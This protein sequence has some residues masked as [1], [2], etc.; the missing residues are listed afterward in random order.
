MRVRWRIFGFMFAFAFLAYLQRQASTIAAE[1]M[2]PELG[3]SQLQFGFLFWAFMLGYTLLQLASGVYGQRWGPRWMFFGASIVAAL[4]VL[5]TPLA[6]FVAAGTVLFGVLLVAQLVLGIAQAPVFP[7]ASGIFEAWFPKQ[8]WALVQ[9][10]ESVGQNLGAALAP[11]MIATI[12]HSFGWRPAVAAVALVAIPFIALW[13]WYGRDTPAEHPRVSQI[14]LAELGDD[15]TAADRSIDW[16]RLRRLLANRDVLTI[17]ASY[18]I[19]NYV[20]YL[21]SVWSFLYLVQERHFTVLEGGWLAAGPPLAAAL[22]AGAGGKIAET[23][24]ARYGSRWGFRLVP[25][26]ALPVSGI[27]L[28]AAVTVQNGYWAAAAMSA[29]FG[30]IELVEGPAWAAVMNVARDDTMA[31]TGI[32]N[33]GGCIGGLVGVPIVAYLSGER[34]WTAAIVIGAVAALV[35]GLAWLAADPSRRFDAAPDAA[36]AAAASQGV[37]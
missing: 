11:P 12:M 27:C 18:T 13:V 37:S 17:T 22:G 4:A 2:M 35:S 25:L 29:A 10:L 7:V 9:G 1:R 23:L 15:H 28:A 34:M 20:F 36:V 8:R 26:V 21:L 30:S 31:A 32:L 3:F 19:M 6:P 14:E 33:T 24:C 16:R 5:A